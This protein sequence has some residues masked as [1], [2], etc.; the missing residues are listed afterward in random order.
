M[1]RF[2][3][4]IETLSANSYTDGG[5]RGEL[6]SQVFIFDACQFSIIPSC[7]GKHLWKVSPATV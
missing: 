4:P 1:L 6:I 5:S 2:D 3:W 7:S